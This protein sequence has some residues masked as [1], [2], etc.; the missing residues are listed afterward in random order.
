MICIQRKER[1]KEKKEKKK[2]ARRKGGG[3]F[4]NFTAYNKH[5]SSKQD[6]Y[7]HTHTSPDISATTVG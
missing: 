6:T 7:T 2:K 4:I 5:I 3:G 1:V